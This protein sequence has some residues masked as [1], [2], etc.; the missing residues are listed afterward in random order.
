M[1]KN[2]ITVLKE[3]FHFN[4]F[5]DKQ[6]DIIKNVIIDKKDVCAIMFTG[7]GKSLCYQFP[8]VYTN[9]VSIIISPLLFLYTPKIELIISLLPLPSKPAIPN[10]SPCQTL[11]EIPFMTL[12]T[13]KLLTSKIGDLLLSICLFLPETLKS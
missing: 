2:Y 1:D 6:L 9:K 3:H 11:N 4:K 5:R 13:S 8:P 7:A 12:P 10:I